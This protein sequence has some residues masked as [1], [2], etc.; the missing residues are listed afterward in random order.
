MKTWKIVSP[1]LP[2]LALLWSLAKIWP[3]L[4]AVMQ[5][6]YIYSMEARFT[7]LS[8]LPYP[9]FLYAWIYSSTNIFGSDFYQAVKI[10]NA[11]FFALLLLFTYLIAKRFVS[12]T[13]SIL[14]ASVTALSPTHLYLS[15]FMPDMPFFTLVIGTVWLL[16]VAVEKN[17]LWW[18]AIVGV[19]LGLASLMKPHALFAVPALAILAFLNSFK[20]IATEKRWINGLSGLGYFLGAFLITKLGLGFVLAGPTGITL[21]GGYGGADAVIS[22][23]SSSTESKPANGVLQRTALETVLGITPGHFMVHLSLLI[24]VAG[25][26]LI[27]PVS[28]LLKV[29]K[30]SDSISPAGNL[31]LVVGLISVSFALA[32]SFFEGYISTGDDHTHRILFRYYEFIYPLLLLATVVA[33]KYVAPKSWVRA[34]QALVVS[35][36]SIFVVSFFLDSS[37]QIQFSDSGLIS[38]IVR[39]PPLAIF[40]VVVTLGTAITWLIKAEVGEKVLPWATALFLILFGAAAQGSLL[41]DVGSQYAY[42]DVAGRAAKAELP[43][44]KGQDLV[45]IS[46][47]RTQAFVVKFWVDKPQITEVLSMGQSPVALTDLGRAKYAVV[48]DGIQVEGN[49]PVVTSGDRYQILDLK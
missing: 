23:L 19:M 35:V 3:V 49:H 18:W 30:K 22:N 46:K 45:V 38:G 20:N 21:F 42:F 43:N 9:N 29:F 4:P 27:L 1:I 44:T 28:I 5:D 14:I 11:V 33:A 37:F 7:P 41:H 31:L 36:A 48:L 17:V 47:S 6:E 2:L 16:L 10:Y 25:V 34:M 8:Q 13:Y 24:F 39:N 32:I 40:F 15:Y 26:A 12:H